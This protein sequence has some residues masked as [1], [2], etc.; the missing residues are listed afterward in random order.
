MVCFGFFSS[1]FSLPFPP[2][3][4]Q[5]GPREGR[6][7]VRSGLGAERFV[8][9]ERLSWSISEVDRQILAPAAVGSCLQGR[10]AEL[11]R[12]GGKGKRKGSKSKDRKNQRRAYAEDLHEMGLL[13]DQSVPPW[14][15]RALRG[16]R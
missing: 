4:F 10:G 3:P 8:T 2:Q 13:L 6:G 15:V 1:L 16:P 14:S 12:M 9:L 7:A 11:G 5:F